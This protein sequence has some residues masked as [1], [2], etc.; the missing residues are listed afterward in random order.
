MHARD[1]DSAQLARLYD[2]LA[3]DLLNFHY[4]PLACAVALGWDGVVIEEIPTHIEL[5]G[6]RLTMS[7]RDGD[8]CLRVVTKVDAGCFEEAWLAAVERASALPP[9][10]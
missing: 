4:D 10:T 8:P 6:R 1:N 3:D 7:R 2:G 5:G 9:A